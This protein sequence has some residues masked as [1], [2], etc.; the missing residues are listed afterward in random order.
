[1][2]NYV[3]INADIKASR[4]LHDYERYEGQLFL[5]SAIVQI[6]ENYQA[7]I[8]ASFMITKG[9]E[10]QGVL[11]NL[12]QVSPIMLDFE[13]LLYP[14]RLRFG[15][16]FGAIQKMGSNIPI[17]MDG[18]AF[19]LASSGLIFAKKEKA[20]VHV[21]TRNTA[22]DLSLNSIYKMVYLIKNRWSEIHYKRYWRYK[23]L[24]TCKLVAQEERVSTQAVWDS[25]HSSGAFE[26]IK[27]EHTLQKLFG[28]HQLNQ[29]GLNI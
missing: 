16:G 9:D 23:E 24:G 28:L 18:Q 5:K 15:V 11:K 26:L 13:H 2:Q 19:H 7:S 10:F 27:V 1:M 20:A 25:L 6:N 29:P 3:V 12:D 8:E 17:E 14:L 22:F 4:K 21:D